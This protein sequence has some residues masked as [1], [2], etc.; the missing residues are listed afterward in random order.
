[1]IEWE[2]LI[3]GVGF[4]DLVEADGPRLVAGQYGDGCVISARR[5]GLNVYCRVA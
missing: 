1:M 3:A 5:Q 4:D 2:C